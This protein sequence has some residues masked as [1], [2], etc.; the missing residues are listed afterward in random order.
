MVESREETGVHR[1]LTERLVRNWLDYSGQDT[2]KVWRMT[3]YQRERQSYVSRAG[4]DVGEQVSDGRTV[5]REM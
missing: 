3:G 2:L 4:G 5:L 1:S